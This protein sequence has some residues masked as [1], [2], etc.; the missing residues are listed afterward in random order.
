MVGAGRPSSPIRK[1]SNSLSPI[2]CRTLVCRSV[3]VHVAVEQSHDLLVRPLDRLRRPT[4]QAGPRLLRG[5]R[6]GEQER[7]RFRG[8]LVIPLAERGRAERRAALGGVGED[9]HRQRIREVGRALA[10]TVDAFL[11]ANDG[12][13]RLAEGGGAQVRVDRGQAGSRLCRDVVRP[14]E[15]RRGRSS[16]SRASNSRRAISRIVSIASNWMLVAC[17]RVDPVSAIGPV[18]RLTFSI[19]GSSMISRLRT[20]VSRSR[21]SGLL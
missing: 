19:R 12:G 9:V 2:S 6:G 1:R 8:V 7:P 5:R 20:T 15:S 14:A 18:V 21:S 4:K 11:R 17:M 16:P 10:G 13:Q 3:A